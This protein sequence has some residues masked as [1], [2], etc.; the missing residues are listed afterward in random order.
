MFL[1][2]YL[3]QNIIFSIGFLKIHWYGL[4]IMLAVT[5][6]FFITLK[7]SQK[8]GWQKEKI[9][10]L[11][12]WLIVAG[13]IGARLY[14]FF[15]EITYYWRQPWEFFYLWQG[16]LGIYGAII[17]GL[18]V[19]YFFGKDNTE[20]L[21]LSDILAPAVALGLAIGRWG[22]YFNQEIYGQPTNL[23]WAIPI[24]FS[25][26]LAGYQNYIFFQPV[27][28]YESLCCLFLFLILIIMHWL[29]LKNKSAEQRFAFY[30]YGNVFFVFLIL[31]SLERFF[32]EL[33]RIDYQ[34]IFFAWRLG[35]WSSLILGIIALIL[36][37]KNRKIY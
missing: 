10:D 13:L 17:G 15:S 24:E 14:H 19:V 8:Y 23:P 4:L 2:T 36:I 11:F 9:W 33:L 28:L 18:V 5:S 27:F 26:R 30:N 3:P 35:Q 7:I 6:G 16:G 32:M 1:H 12:F 21:L 34:P 29:R 22:N 37:V 25:N 20:R 31:Y